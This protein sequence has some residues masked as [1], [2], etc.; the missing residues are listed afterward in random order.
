MNNAIGIQGHNLVSASNNL[1]YGNTVNW[2]DG[3]TPI[4]NVVA[5]P[6]LDA[7]HIPR[8][9]SPAVNAGLK[10]RLTRDIY[11]TL[12]RRLTPTLGAIEVPKYRFSRG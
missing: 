9:N 7:L 2:Q 12:R 1:F 3:I 5:N 6:N 10:S 11:G 8:I 4:N